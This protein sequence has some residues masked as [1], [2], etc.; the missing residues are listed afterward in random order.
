MQMVQAPRASAILYTVLKSRSDVRPWLLPA[1]ICP[2]VPITFLK[3]NV[4]FELV[5]ISAETL[6]M[7]LEQAESLM[8]TRRFGGILYA[9]TYGESSTPETFFRHIKRLDESILIVDDRCL[10]VPALQANPASLADVQLYSTGYAKYV[11]L[12]RGGYAFL[13]E[14][15]PYKPVNLF[16]DAQANAQLEA[17]YKAA[18]RNRKKFAY[19]DSNWLQTNSTLTSWSD[20]RM[21]VADELENSRAQR[22]K[23]NA[24]YE[25][26]LPSDVQFPSNF[27]NWRFNIRVR[28]KARI[29]NA[30]FGAGLFASSHYASLAGI[31]RD[32]TCPDAELLHGSVINLFNDHHFNEAKAE[33][34]CEVILQNLS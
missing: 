17:L 32:G 22:S 3:A 25:S 28:N 8:A 18:I 5:D 19:E 34:V 30:I 10:C 33:K 26:R 23:L 15:V 31:M 7:D 14:K 12:G 16:F 2:I 21:Q 20:Y 11:D 9:H 13:E 6:H 29:L 1:N 24:I 27:Q 4:D